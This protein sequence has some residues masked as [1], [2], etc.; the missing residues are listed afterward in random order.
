MAQ[1]TVQD[2][3]DQAYA[4]HMCQC[5]QV[6]KESTERVLID[7]FR[8]DCPASFAREVLVPILRQAINDDEVAFPEDEADYNR[9]ERE[10][11]TTARHNT[12]VSL[13]D[14]CEL[15]QMAFESLK[16]GMVSQYTSQF[17]FDSNLTPARA[18]KS[19]TNLD[20][21]ELAL[22]M[23]YNGLVFDSKNQNERALAFYQEAY[24]IDSSYR[25]KG[26][27]HLLSKKPAAAPV[28]EEKPDTK[29]ASPTPT[30]NTATQEEID[31]LFTQKYCECLE[32]RM[33]QPS[34]KLIAAF[35]EDCYREFIVD[36]MYPMTR[37]LNP[38]DADARKK[39]RETMLINTL[40]NTAVALVDN[41]EAYVRAINLLNEQSA[42]RVLATHKLMYGPFEENMALVKELNPKQ[43][44][45]ALQFKGVYL[46]SVQEFDEAIKYFNAAQE[47]Y[48]ESRNL[49]L[50][51]M[52]ERE[53]DNQ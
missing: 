28:S 53:R 48:P 43:R 16:N 38:G 21:E 4:D 17:G 9:M 19:G 2:R 27:M 20:S 23:M 49:A 31:A 30:T 5:M 22:L 42:E 47:A 24:Q 37:G 39:T 15:Y 8:Q 11:V 46:Q 35:N 10:F 52:A 45:R 51:R 36:Y 3:I 1:N 32:K 41:C 40:S 18:R 34:E 6:Y 50:I 7:G 13:L 29:P 26:F 12:V 14:S 25:V 44:G 33:D